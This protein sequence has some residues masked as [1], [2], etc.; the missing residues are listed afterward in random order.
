MCLGAIYWAR[1]SAIYYAATHKEAAAAGFDD[2]FIY[3]QICLPAGERALP[4]KQ[5]LAGAGSDPFRAWTENLL[6]SPY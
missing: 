6:R 4:M 3:Q 1:P 5:L 2:S